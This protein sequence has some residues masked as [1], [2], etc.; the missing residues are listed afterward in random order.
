MIKEI[1]KILLPYIAPL[2]YYPKYLHLLKQIDA[3]FEHQYDVFCFFPAYHIGGAEKVH[4]QILQ[5]LNEFR[6]ATFITHK[7]KT[8]AFKENYRTASSFFIDIGATGNYTFFQKRLAKHIATKLNTINYFCTLFGCNAVLFY[9][10]LPII[11]NDKIKKV[12]LLHAFAPYIKGIEHA[13]I[14]YVHLLD[15]RIVINKKTKEDYSIQYREHSIN[16]QMLE[17]IQIIYNASDKECV[18]EEK[19]FSS[20]L[21]CLFVGRGSPEKRF[22]LFLSVADECRKLQLPMQFTAVG[23]LEHYSKENRSVRFLGEIKDETELK[24]VYETHQILLVTSIYEGFP[25]T[26]MEAMCNGLISISTD[27]GGISE[28][29]HPYK[30]GFL[31]ENQ[32]NEKKIVE[33]IVRLL[34]CLIE[35][36]KQL[37]ELSINSIYYAQQN[38]NLERFKKNY[39]EALINHK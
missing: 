30:N 20:P 25:L 21:K 38:F 35:N 1:K 33:H 14:N 36:P 28:H 9:Q 29:I 34:I 12:D 4:L 6:V 39:I 18:K 3:C 32:A 5:A 22:H 19:D 17:R 27:V 26:I 13:S 10:Q 23:D 24:K 37:S 7:S 11:K 31:I 8:D 2:I 15:T 16:E